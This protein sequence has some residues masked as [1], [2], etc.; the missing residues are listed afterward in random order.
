MKNR[1]WIIVQLALIGLLLSLTACVYRGKHPDT[2]TPP[3]PRPMEG[4]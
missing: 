3:W 4:G 1:I 2:S